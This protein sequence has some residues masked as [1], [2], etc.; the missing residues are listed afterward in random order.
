MT[1]SEIA[2]ISG[3]HAHIYYEPETK[4]AAAAVRDALDTQFRGAIRLGC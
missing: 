1:A 4:G 3:Y 2:N